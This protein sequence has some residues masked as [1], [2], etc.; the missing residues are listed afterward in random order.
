MKGV[1]L[2]TNVF[3]RHL[4]GDHPQHS[5]AARALFEAIERG[6]VAVWT[7]ETVLTEIV[8]TLSGSVYNQSPAQIA[9]ALASLLSLPGL[10]VPRKRMYP[11]V[12]ELYTT[13]GIDYVDAYHAAL[14]ES[15]GQHGV[16]SFDAHFDR[17]TDMHRLDPARDPLP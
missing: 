2:D 11:R 9:A 14:I 4:T 17:I 12:L 13:L 5:P 7:T 10:H 8:W 16:W 1:F 6:D 3:L 15:R